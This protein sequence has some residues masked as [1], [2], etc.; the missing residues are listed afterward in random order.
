MDGY[1]SPMCNFLKRPEKTMTA[2]E[3]VR[4][5]QTETHTHTQNAQSDINL[6]R[7]TGAYDS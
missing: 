4:Y 5:Q 3:N 7:G 2:M 1:L 6:L